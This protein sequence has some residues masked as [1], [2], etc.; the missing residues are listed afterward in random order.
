MSDFVPLLAL[1][2]QVA[3]TDFGRGA[4][5]ECDAV[6]LTSPCTKWNYQI[7]SENEVESCM[8]EAIKLAMS[9]PCACGPV[10]LD[11]PADIL[12]K[13]VLHDK[14]VKIHLPSKRNERNPNVEDDIRN[15][16]EMILSA[17]KPIIHAGQGTI[18]C[19]PLLRQ[20]AKTFQ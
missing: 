8:E 19:A 15:V 1:T 3:T 10:H 9:A 2:G 17:R 4:F 14:K 11:I 20:F 12:T 13:N 6:A 18:N 5:Q 7:Q 16:L